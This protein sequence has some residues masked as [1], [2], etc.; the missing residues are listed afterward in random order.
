MTGSP[1]IPPPFRLEDHPPFRNWAAF[2]K[3][4]KDA[5]ELS[6][7]RALETQKIASDFGKLI[8]TNLHLINA[9]GLFAAPT[10]F[11][12][13]VS[14]SQPTFSDKMR[15][16]VL[17]MSFLA[18]GL[19]LASTTAFFVYRNFNAIAEQWS[20][21]RIMIEADLEAVN[22]SLDREAALKRFFD[23]K[24]SHAIADAKIKTN[25]VRAF[26]S[27]WS[28]AACFI[29]ACVCLAIGVR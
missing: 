13:I 21:D 25:Y 4:R 17:P 18:A 9:G 8:I 27:G 10:L 24:V 26:I 20:F 5:S 28:S 12:T 23:A 11:N 2:V 14:S 1:Q 19:L 7:R 6:D 3:A 22:P 15:F 29:L 16:L